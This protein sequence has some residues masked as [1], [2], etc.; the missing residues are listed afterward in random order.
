MPDLDWL[1]LV[2]RLQ[3]N[4]SGALD[5]LEKKYRKRVVLSLRRRF[6]CHAIDVGGGGYSPCR[7]CI[8]SACD[9]V[10]E[11]WFKGFHMK[12]MAGKG[13]DPLYSYYWRAVYHHTVDCLEPEIL[14]I[15]K[16]SRKVH[17]TL[18]KL[19]RK[20]ISV[21]EAMKEIQKIVPKGVN[22]TPIESLLKGVGQA[23][24]VE[25]SEII[26]LLER[27]VQSPN[28]HLSA[29][30]EYTDDPETFRD[31]SNVEDI[32]GME[33]SFEELLRN[34]ADGQISFDELIASAVT[35]LPETAQEMFTRCELTADEQ[36][37]VVMRHAY[38]Y[39]NQDIADIM[40]RTKDAIESIFYRL[41]KKLDTGQAGSNSTSN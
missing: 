15:E 20:K 13:E 21:V 26:N 24:Y 41:K 39:S 30:D 29:L 12:E 22:I 8:D 14:F 10:R 33:H 35:E 4:D 25:A 5:E 2:H 32:H 27:L 16:I 6:H 19:E 9:E 7:E 36:A 23:G 1:Q 40:G 38:G 37:V 17:S 18:G 28:M 11:D 31:I 3:S 34:Y